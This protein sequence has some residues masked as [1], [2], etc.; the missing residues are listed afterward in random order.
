MSDNSA[1]QQLT[2]A[3]QHL[4]KLSNFIT[5]LVDF[6]HG[7]NPNIDAEL[8]QIK[9]LLSGTPDYFSAAELSVKLKSQLIKES[10]YLRQ[11]NLDTLA[12][13]KVSL[14]KINDLDAVNPS[15]K[16]EISTFLESLGASGDNI[17]SP[18]KQIEQAL[19]LFRKAL[20]NSAL[21]RSQ[22]ALATQ[23]D[24]HARITQELKELLSPYSAKQAEDDVLLELK[25][26]LEVGLDH[27]ELLE[28]CLAMIRFVMKDVVKEASSANRLI[29]DVHKSISKIN[30]GIKT[31]I[32]KSKSRMQKRSVHNNDL[33]EQISAIETALT[34]SQKIE[35][36]RL[37][38]HECL[39]KMQSSMS[40]SESDE[41]AE[42][43]KMMALLESMQKR[44]TELESNAE[45]YKQRLIE[46]RLNAMTDMLTQLPNRLAYE[47][48][49]ASAFAKAKLTGSKLCMAIFDIDHFKDVND[50]YGH[51][52]GDKTLKIIATQI[53][54]NLNSSDF[55]AR[56]GGEEFVAV[57]PDSDLQQSFDRLENIREAIAKLP[58]MFKGTRVTVTMSI[59]LTDVLE[60]DSIESAFEQSDKR[61]Y[62]AKQNGRNQTQF[63]DL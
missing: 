12:E 59:G 21:E 42:Q 11:Q 60:H 34:D 13:I 61:L 25:E 51:S 6:L 19:R 22:N 1:N 14:Q 28:C 55:V 36:L 15:T 35:D 46:Q 38:T 50:K 58:F 39:G 4:D 26:K 62:Q 47:E 16:R 57:M 41:K 24:M 8:N 31:T 20:S 9:K 30:V 2:T 7:A 37:Q 33:R 48:K 49:M 23:Q 5:N 45:N 17:A 10:Q 3:R 18:V 63:E 27:D 32:E 54:K 53:K 29:H 43:T 56:W 44:L 52:V 40:A